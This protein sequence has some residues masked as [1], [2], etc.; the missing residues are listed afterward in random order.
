[1]VI[2]V[3]QFPR[4]TSVPRHTGWEKC[5]TG[6]AALPQQNCAT[7]ARSGCWVRQNMSRRLLWWN[8][9]QSFRH[10]TKVSY[11]RGFVKKYHL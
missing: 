6:I 7:A 11:A 10:Q 3:F 5:F 9:M 2:L 4:H 8:R 1:M